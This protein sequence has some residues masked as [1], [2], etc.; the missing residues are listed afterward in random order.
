MAGEEELGASIPT[1]FQR[2][3]SWVVLNV[4]GIR[5]DYNYSVLHRIEELK[6]LFTCMYQYVPVCTSM[7]Q[8]VL[9]FE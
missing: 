6:Q 2:N 4:V 1:V 9:D 5:R 8:Y 3:I 7:Y